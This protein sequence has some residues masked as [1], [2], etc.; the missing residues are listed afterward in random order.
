MFPL[1]VNWNPDTVFLRLGSFEV[2]YY[3]LSWAI[4]I[5]IGMW[6][7]S[8]FVKREGLSQKVF[9][10]VFWYGTLATVIGARL[11]HVIFYEPMDYLRQPLH[12]LYFREGGMAS[13]G[14]ALGL[15][16]GLWLFSRKHKLPY[17]W[18]LDRIMVAVTI[19]GAFVRL[20][21]LMNSEIYGIETTLPWGFIFERMG[22]TLPKHP[23]QIYESLCYIM[24]FIVLY[25]MYFKG[26]MGRRRPG[27]MFGVGLLFVFASRFFIEF[28][29]NPQVEFEKSM[30][31][32]MGQWLSLPFI[33]LGIY[34]LWWS[35]RKAKQ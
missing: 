27:L 2:Y 20:G 22:E 33:I 15:L 26:D 8:I 7:F 35:Y 25:L 34:M 29:K 11:G 18:S 21:N 5:G 9:D 17:V 3:G 4:A 6:L 30:T 1:Y 10:T 31:L 14:A 19:G 23:T 12:I 24:G 28:V 32:D 16:L 13:H